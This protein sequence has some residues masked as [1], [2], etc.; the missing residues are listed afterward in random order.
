M[1]VPSDKDYIETKLIKRGLTKLKP[2]FAHLAEW[3]ENQYSI[4]VLN[5]YY[6]ITT[7]PHNR[8]FPRLNIIFENEK[9]E[10]NFR[11][12]FLGNFDSDKQQLIAGKFE[13]LVNKRNPA[14][15]RLSNFL[16]RTEGSTY[17]T[18]G[19]LVILDSFEPVARDEAN[20]SIPKAEIEELKTELHAP[21]IWEISRFGSRTT[22]FYYT[23]RQAESAKGSALFARLTTRY[24]QLLK[25][26]DEFEYFDEDSFTL[27]I[28]SKE[29]FEKNF[30][31]SW[32]YYYR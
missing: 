3:I 20:E 29:N 28:D 10:L 19:L 8:P 9:D 2:D 5:V 24:Y 26:Y 1:I 18:K 22:V 15:A 23:D 4:E 25:N 13:E 6:D 7:G 12:G 21:E 32:F 27:D 30:E 16:G 31:S 17:D 14:N 11:N